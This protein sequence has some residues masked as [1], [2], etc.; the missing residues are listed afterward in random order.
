[1]EFYD[2]GGSESLLSRARRDAKRFTR[3]QGN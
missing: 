1:M 2:R 3:G